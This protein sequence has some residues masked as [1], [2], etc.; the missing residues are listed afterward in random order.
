M[1][2][3]DNIV[4]ADIRNFQVRGTLNSFTVGLGHFGKFSSKMC[5]LLK[6]NS[7]LLSETMLSSCS[8]YN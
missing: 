1:S 6:I 3:L 7:I 5:H 4:M 2:H 8:R